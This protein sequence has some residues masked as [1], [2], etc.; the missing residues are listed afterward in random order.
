[1]PK[2]TRIAA[3]IWDLIIEGKE[4]LKSQIIQNASAEEKWL[5]VHLSQ[6]LHSG[7]SV[8]SLQHPTPAPLKSECVI[9]LD[10]SNGDLNFR[11]MLCFFKVKLLF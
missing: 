10:T 3:P 5:A 11:I 6:P 1:M 7:P 2:W 8:T 9:S 4:D